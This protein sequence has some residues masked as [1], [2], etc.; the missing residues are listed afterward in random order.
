ME[1]NHVVVASFGLATDKSADPPGVVAL[2][3]GGT[4]LLART[5]GCSTSKA[6]GG[7][8]EGGNG[9]ELHF[10]SWESG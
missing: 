5:E 10:D 8:E 3:V 9:S 4:A 6:T 1:R 2:R 7:E